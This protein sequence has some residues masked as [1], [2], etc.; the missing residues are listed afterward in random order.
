MPP[1]PPAL[2]VNLLW[3]DDDAPRAG[4]KSMDAEE[5]APVERMIKLVVV[6][7]SSSKESGEVVPMPTFPALSILIRSVITPELGVVNNAKYP[8][9]LLSVAFSLSPAI[10]A[11]LPPAPAADL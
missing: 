11:K 9:S 4:W 6:D 8:C 2:I 10:P 7:D 1:K 3:F 5:V